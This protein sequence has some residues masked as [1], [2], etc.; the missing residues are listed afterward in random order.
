M[1]NI[2][3]VSRLTDLPHEILESAR[4]AG[5]ES[6]EKRRSG[7]YMMIDHEAVI[8]RVNKHFKGKLEIIDTKVA[9]KKYKWLQ[10]YRWK[11]VDRGKDEYTECVDEDFGGGYFLRIL[12]N[13][14]VEFPLQSCLMISSEGMK[15]NVH[16]IIIAEEGSDSRIITGCTLHPDVRSGQHIGISE[17]FI[18]KDAK[19]NF[20]MIHNWNESAKV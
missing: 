2:K 5:I 1:N 17:F 15:Q 13:A 7:T 16:N 8:S 11:L 6:N 3:K 10:D 14:R 19:L 20:T 18:K 4:K 9:L 12:K